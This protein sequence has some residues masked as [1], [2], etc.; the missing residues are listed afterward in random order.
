MN[1]NPGKAA[2]PAPQV[3]VVLPAYNAAAHVE[4]A[5]RSVLAQT[6]SDFELIVID[7]GST[8]TTLDILRRLQE[9]DARIRII[10]RPNRGLVASLNEGIAA[11]RGTWI[12]R[13]DADDI[14]RPERLERQ[15][16]WLMRSGADICGSAI[17]MFGAQG[18]GVVIAHPVS[19][20]AVGVALLFGTAFAH[21]TVVMRAAKARELAYD[22]ALEKCE[23]YDLWERAAAVGWRFTNVPEV[24]LDY[25]VHAQQI[26]VASRERQ[27]TLAQNVRRRAWSRVAD[28]WQLAGE[29]V[30]SV[31]SLRGDC[32]KDV[33][34]ARVRTA[35]ER[36][37]GQLDGEALE[38]ARGHITRLYFRAAVQGPRAWRDWVFLMRLRGRRVPSKSSFALL[39]VSALRLSAQG[40]IYGWLQRRWSPAGNL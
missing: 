37:L 8:D 22:P 16:Q 11:A 4:E 26:S 18:E 29:D 6:M 33:D 30:N 31:L 14:C 32:A 17:R 27:Q 1:L 36:V 35:L 24:L 40:R 15:L 12:A 28:S 13:M 19:H 21:P 38:V 7:D 34:L 10:S 39:G 23:D 5:V 3:S 20:E 25:R 9:V 2:P